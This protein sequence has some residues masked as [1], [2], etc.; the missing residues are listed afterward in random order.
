M[1]TLFLLFVLFLSGCSSVTNNMMLATEGT[2]Q[3]EVILYRPSAFPAAANGMLVGF[4]ENYFAT[5]RNNQYIR[6]KINSGTYDF[7]AKA[8]GSQASNLKLTLEPDQK[9]CIKSNINPTVAAAALIPLVANMVSWFQLSEV[10]CPDDSF[11]ADYSEAHK[12]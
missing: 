2:P 10:P 9:V 8:N 12:S 1:K 5:L 11:F 4:N 6:V 7:Q 3:T